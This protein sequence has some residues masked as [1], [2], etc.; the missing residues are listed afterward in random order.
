MLLRRLMLV[1]AFVVALVVVAQERKVQ[2]LPFADQRWVHFG[3]ALGT[4]T[5]DIDF[6]HSG[7]IT[8]D[9]ECWSAELPGFEPGFNVSLLADMYMNPYMNLRFTPTLYF[10]SKSIVLREHLG[11]NSFT[12]SL[13]STYISLP[14][15][16]KVAT[17][18]INNYRPYVLGGVG[19]MVDLSKKENLMLRPNLVDFFWSVGIGCD[20]YLYYFKLIPE[21]KFT[22]GFSDMLDRDRSDLREP[23]DIKYTESLSAAFSRMVTLSFYFE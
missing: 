12:E 9:G 8:A 5:Q 4:H 16:V 1:V 7:V 18:R 23:T 13:K 14:L 3:F 11:G 2:N 21:L 10:G 15:D 19:G 6:V 17:M 20:L 22:F